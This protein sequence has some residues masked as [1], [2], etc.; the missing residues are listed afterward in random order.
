MQMFITVNTILLVIPRRV[1]S[2]FSTKGAS[3]RPCYCADSW[4]AVSLDGD[5]DDGK[6]GI[7]QNLAVHS[8]GNDVRGM[9]RQVSASLCLD[10]G[11]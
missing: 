7:C 9:C 2:K 8:S 5:A 10:G 11:A 3:Y 4:K 1:E 6:G